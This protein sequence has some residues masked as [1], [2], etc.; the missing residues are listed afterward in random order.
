MRSILGV[1]ER[2]SQ[3]PAIALAWRNE[4]PR[5]CF[6]AFFAFCLLQSSSFGNLDTTFPA[7]GVSHKNKVFTRHANYPGIKGFSL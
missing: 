4:V 6:A 7:A 1:E 3:M 5:T 2:S